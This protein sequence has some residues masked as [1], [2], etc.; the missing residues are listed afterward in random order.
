MNLSNAGRLLLVGTLTAGIAGLIG[1]TVVAQPV[2][3]GQPAQP[4]VV[5]NDATQAVPVTATQD[6]TWNVDVA[7]FPAPAAPPLWQGEPYI[8]QLPREDGTLGG[9]SC[10]SPL[11]AGKVLFLER[12]V[13]ESEYGAAGTRFAGLNPHAWL[14]V[15][16]DPRVVDSGRRIAVPIFPSGHREQEFQ[17]ATYKYGHWT[18]ALDIGQPVMTDLCVGSL[19]GD[20]R[21]TLLG[22]LVP[23]P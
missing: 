14:T 20:Y 22:Y 11:P 12:V 16:R 13:V 9:S 1:G 3:P 5:T 18:G 10:I 23:A 2:E 8:R 19:S 15:D 6:G 4:V 21:F 7:N 17:D